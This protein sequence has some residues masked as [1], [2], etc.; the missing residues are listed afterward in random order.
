LIT[1]N[2]NELFKSSVNSIEIAPGE[3]KLIQIERNASATGWFGNL[4]FHMD[5]GKHFSID[6]LK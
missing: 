5:N 4:K 2:Q 1:P 3:M 6:V